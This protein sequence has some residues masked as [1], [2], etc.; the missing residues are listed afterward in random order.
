MEAEAISH[1]PRS[2]NVPKITQPQPQPTGRPRQCAARPNP[3]TQQKNKQSN[4]VHPTS[5]LTPYIGVRRCGHL[6]FV[7]EAA[8]SR[9]SRCG[10]PKVKDMHEDETTTYNEGGNAEQF[11]RPHLQAGSRFAEIVGLLLPC[12]LR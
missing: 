4:S 3:N 8:L 1:I 2:G 6:D 5:I 12:K 10:S 9:S 7:V 11:H